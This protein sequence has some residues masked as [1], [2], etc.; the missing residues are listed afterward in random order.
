V[1]PEPGPHGELGVEF[2]RCSGLLRAAQARNSLTQPQLRAAYSSLRLQSRV[3]RSQSGNGIWRGQ[4]SGVSIGVFIVNIAIRVV[5]RHRC[6]LGYFHAD[7]DTLIRG[8]SYLL[9]TNNTASY[10]SHKLDSITMGTLKGGLRVPRF[11]C[12]I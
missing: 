4:D 12:R 9:E 1:G 10:N 5:D 3:L 2:S 11:S 6:P 7:K 8:R